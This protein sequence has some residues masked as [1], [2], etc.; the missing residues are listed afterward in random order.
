[1]VLRFACDY[2]PVTFF[3]HFD[4]LAHVKDRHDLY[5]SVCIFCHKKFSPNTTMR[6]F[7]EHL[8]LYCNFD[9]NEEPI[10]LK[11]IGNIVVPLSNNNQ[12]TDHWLLVEGQKMYL[13]FLLGNYKIVPYYWPI[14]HYSDET[15]LNLI[16]WCDKIDCEIC[17][18]RLKNHFNNYFEDDDDVDID[19]LITIM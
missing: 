16:R 12:K 14:F 9:T 11:C 8:K 10:Y 6:S 2:C 7:E 15:V 19:M 13:D 4:F 3:N 1:M 5:L 18:N 17:T